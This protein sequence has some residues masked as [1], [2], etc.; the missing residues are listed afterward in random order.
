M[1]TNPD[2]E[3]INQLIN[4]KRYEEAKAILRQSS[5]PAS[6]NWLAR[7]E[8]LFPSPPQSKVVAEPRSDYGTYGLGVEKYGHVSTSG[9][10]SAYRPTA[11]Y[12]R[13]GCLTAFLI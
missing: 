11:Q 1:S 7:L 2:N 3:R 12:E 8:S 4:E 6:Q 13:G 9:S 5:D 10:S